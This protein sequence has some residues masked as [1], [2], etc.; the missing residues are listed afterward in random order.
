MM[1]ETYTGSALTEKVRIQGNGYVGIGTTCAYSPLQVYSSADQKILLSGSANPYIRWQNGGSNRA[2]IQWIESGSIFGFFN[3]A[4]DNFDFFT[5]DSG[6]INLRLKGNDGD[7]WGSV[8]ATDNSGTHQVGILDGDQH[9]AAKHVNDTCWEFLTNNQSRMFINSTGVYSASR[10]GFCY[11]SNCGPY[12]EAG[13]T[14]SA[15]S[16]FLKRHD[17][18]TTVTCLGAGVLC[19]STCVFSPFLRASC[20]SLECACLV[21]GTG[22]FVPVIKAGGGN[23]DLRI[24]SAGTG[25]WI[26]FHANGS[27]R[28]CISTAGAVCAPGCFVSP[29]FCSTYCV[30]TPQVNLTSDGL[31]TFYGNGS[32]NHAIMNRDTGGNVADDI[33]I[34]SYGAVHVNLDSNNNNTANAGFNVYRHGGGTGNLSDLLF[35]VDGE[36]STTCVFGDLCVTGSV[37]A[38]GMV[39]DCLASQAV[40]TGTICFNTSCVTGYDAVYDVYVSSNPNCGG[41]VNYRDIVHMTVYVTTGWNGSAVTKYINHVNNFVRGAVHDSGGGSVTAVPKLLVGTTGCECYAAACATCLQ[42][43]V[44]GGSYKYDTCVKIKQVL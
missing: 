27:M 44:A 38:D 39:G 1:F 17:G 25:G 6:A 16:V 34:N 35:A 3:S 37:I 32:S 43:Q 22:G 40:C 23:T 24:C 36:G 8:Y 19:A 2:Y 9:W 20:S 41:S 26:D 11:P 10:L 30:D 7:I 28:L 29:V 12:F 18:S 5:H 15:P 4:G 42:I 33:R 21:V 31:I 14:Y 13:G